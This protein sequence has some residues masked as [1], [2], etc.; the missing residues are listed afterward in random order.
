MFFWITA[1]FSVGFILGLSVVLAVDSNG[2]PDGEEER[3]ALDDLRA[4]IEGHDLVG[5]GGYTRVI[6]VIVFTLVWLPAM[7]YSFLKPDK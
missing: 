2:D 7:I 4:T 1:Y 3:K 6:I 5:N